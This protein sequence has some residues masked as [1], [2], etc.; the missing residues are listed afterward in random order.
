MVPEMADPRQ[1]RQ[2]LNI[3]KK[4][5]YSRKKENTNPKN[6]GTNIKNNTHL[7]N[8]ILQANNPKKVI[9]TG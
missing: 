3:M 6:V 5:K 8:L 2:I 1:Y 4:L 7:G 9:I